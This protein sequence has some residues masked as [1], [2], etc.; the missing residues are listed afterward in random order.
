MKSYCFSAPCEIRFCPPPVP[1]SA[2]EKKWTKPPDGLPVHSSSSLLSEL[3]GRARVTLGLPHDAAG[4]TVKQIPDSTPIQTP[5]FQSLAAFPVTGNRISNCLKMNQQN[6]A[7][8]AV[9]LRIENV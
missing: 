6:D 7:Q 2:K 1:D 5:A 9:E 4:N 8:T 3:A